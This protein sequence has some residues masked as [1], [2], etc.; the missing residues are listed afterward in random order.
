M[1]GIC[2]PE[3]W[4][5]PQVHSP[6]H[7]QVPDILLDT[8]SSA[9]AFEW[10]ASKQ[11]AT[12]LSLQLGSATLKFA[13]K[14]FAFELMVDGQPAMRFNEHQLFDWEHHRAKQVRPPHGRLS[15]PHMVPG[16]IRVERYCQIRHNLHNW[17]MRLWV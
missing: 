14:P 1:Q 17:S 7:M 4:C 2:R 3:C 16:P 10:T 5:K 13:F 15:M 12:T 9:G 11:T 8:V 6:L